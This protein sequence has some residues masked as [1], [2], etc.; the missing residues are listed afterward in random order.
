[1]RRVLRNIWDII[2]A[3]VIIA[4]FLTALLIIVL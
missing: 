3:I 2:L 4:V 1:M